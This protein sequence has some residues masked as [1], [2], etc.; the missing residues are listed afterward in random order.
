M[1]WCQDFSFENHMNLLLMHYLSIFCIFLSK[2]PL[3]KIRSIVSLFWNHCLVSVPA[4][5]MPYTLKELL[6]YSLCIGADFKWVEWS[7][8]FIFLRGRF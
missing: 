4:E 3:G 1:A 8:D 2:K 6:L 5:L 7:V